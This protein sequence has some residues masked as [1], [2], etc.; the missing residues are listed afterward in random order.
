LS[1]GAWAAARSAS[2]VTCSSARAAARYFGLVALLRQSAT[3]RAS[4]S[5]WYT[6]PRPTCP[7]S[8]RGSRPER[9]ITR[10]ITRPM[11]V[12]APTIRGMAG[13]QETASAAAAV[14]AGGELVPRA[15]ARPTGPVVIAAE[16]LAPTRGVL[17]VLAGLG[18][19]EE[20]LAAAWLTSLRSPRIRQAYARDLRGRAVVARAARRG[21]AGRGPGARGHVGGWAAGPGRKRPAGGG[22]RRCPAFT[23][24]APLTT[25]PTCP[26]LRPLVMSKPRPVPAPSRPVARTAPGLI[27]RY[28]PL[29]SRRISLPMPS[30]DHRASQ[31][32]GAAQRP[33]LLQS[34]GRSI[35][36]Y[37]VAAWPV[38]AAL[39]PHTQA[40]LTPLVTVRSKSLLTCAQSATTPRR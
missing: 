13:D 27:R 32:P 1:S 16:L 8:R 31:R 23:A 11:P 30:R 17:P 36:G 10:C 37:L 21:C 40:A 19:R 22:C 15:G 24:T 7:W 35:A 25:W 3:Q 5:R 4:L 38:M 2:A 34:A 6:R 14:T 26:N 29:S 28:R 20:L 33:R 39:L 9:V 18:E 12:P